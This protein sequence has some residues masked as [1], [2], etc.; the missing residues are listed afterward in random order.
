MLRG[1][2]G[3]HADQI[4]KLVPPEKKHQVVGCSAGEQ[5]KPIYYDYEGCL[6]ARVERKHP[7]LA[8]S[9]SN[10]LP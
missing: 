5:V 10:K 9:P 4:L 8:L 7:F 1:A 2:N 6:K 3:E